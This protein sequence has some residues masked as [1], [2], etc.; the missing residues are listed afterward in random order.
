MAYSI[1][2][3]VIKFKGVLSIDYKENDSIGNSKKHPETEDVLI[4]GINNA[5]I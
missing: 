3:C 5:I 1:K 4:H 2:L